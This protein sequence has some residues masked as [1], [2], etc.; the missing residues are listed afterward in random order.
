MIFENYELLAKN[1]YQV[2]IFG[3]GP[4]GVTL[5]LELEKKDVF[6]KVTID[7][8]FEYKK[9]LEEAKSHSR[10]LLKT[11]SGKF[12]KYTGSEYE[13]LRWF[14]YIHDLTLEEVK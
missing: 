2:I 10:K 11:Y 5:A 14:N 1:K 7:T 12:K 9:Y 13:T 8:T 3:S 6:K 4:A